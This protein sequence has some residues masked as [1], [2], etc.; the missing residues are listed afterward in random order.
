MSLTVLL[1]ALFI[2]L[3][4]DSNATVLLPLEQVAASNHVPECRLRLRSRAVTNVKSISLFAG[5]AISLDLCLRSPVDVIIH[6]LV[7]SNDG[8]SDVISV[9]I[10]SDVIG[11]VNTTD[12]S[13]NGHLWN[14]FHHSGYVGKGGYS[15]GRHSLSITVTDSDEYGVELDT[16]EVGFGA[17]TEFCGASPSNRDFMATTVKCRP[18]VPVPG[19]WM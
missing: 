18:E 2:T 4:W 15:G 13:G 5:E 17:M 3:L 9:T 6:D 11:T 12:E 1:C 8:G 16:I 14:V 19:S 7:Y 10:D